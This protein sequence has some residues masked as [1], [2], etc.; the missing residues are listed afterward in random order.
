MAYFSNMFSS[1]PSVSV[2]GK[3]YNI[4]QTCKDEA[5]VQSL[6]ANGKLNPTS[7]YTLSCAT[8]SYVAGEK[9]G[10]GGFN[11]VYKINGMS[12][13]VVR[14]TKKGTL[15]REKDD[16]IVGLFLQAYMSKPVTEGGVGCPYICRVYEFGRLGA[17]TNDDRV[18]AVLELLP[19]SDLLDVIHFTKRK[20]DYKIG[21]TTAMN[22]RKV[23]EQVLLGL[24]CMHKNRYVH[25][26]M[27]NENVGID[28]DGNAK[29]ID[30]GFSR[31]M[32]TDKL[33]N[34]VQVGTPLFMD[35]E[36][37]SKKRI[38]INSDIYAVGVMVLE[39]YFP[40]TESKD[41]GILLRPIYHK[42]SLYGGKWD[43]FE[44]LYY[45]I[46]GQTDAVKTVETAILVDLLKHMIH[47]DPLKRFTA[48]QC[49]Q[50][51]WFAEQ[52]YGGKALSRGKK[53]VHRKRRGLRNRKT[54]NH[55]TQI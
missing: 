22:M 38:S 15:T 26:D 39:A 34:Q 6:K 48:A 32:P 51:K 50:H 8:N 31:Y 2:D 47:P 45:E 4:T 44:R 29:I 27:K 12:D 43:D 9:L 19:K 7:N 23:F 41:S 1:V 17:G 14:V 52:S 18:Y 37:L 55:K 53:T 54:K 24:D 28:R 46:A 30:F 49:L 40:I 20:I 16:E 25:L 5:L 33:E 35:P 13:R 11:D 10:S 3:S 42:G 21:D 36:F